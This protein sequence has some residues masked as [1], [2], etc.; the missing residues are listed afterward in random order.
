MLAPKFKPYLLKEEFLNLRQEKKEILPSATSI[1]ERIMLADVENYL[2][3]DILVKTDR[4]S[5]ATSLEVR[6]PFLESS[7]VSLEIATF[8]ENKKSKN[9]MDT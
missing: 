4:A 7:W 1:S 6:A 5:M 2:H 9:K 8:Y 3:S